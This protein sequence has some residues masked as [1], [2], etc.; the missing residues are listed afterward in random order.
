[1]KYNLFGNGAKKGKGGSHITYSIHAP[2]KLRLVACTKR[3][4][5]VAVQMAEHVDRSLTHFITQHG[6]HESAMSTD[7]APLI[8]LDYF[9]ISSRDV[10]LLSMVKEDECFMT[11][12]VS[13]GF[14]Q[15]KITELTYTLLPNKFVKIAEFPAVVSTPNVELLDQFPANPK[16]CGK[17]EMAANIVH[18]FGEPEPDAL[19]YNSWLHCDYPALT[20]DLVNMHWSSACQEAIASELWGFP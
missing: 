12:N 13:E 19:S 10:A 7:D 16:Y 18:S 11:I 17:L 5:Q 4:G 3:F 2:L 6:N 9:P 14:M 15:V 8:K 1:M 20:S